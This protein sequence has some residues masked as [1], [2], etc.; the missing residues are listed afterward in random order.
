MTTSVLKPRSTSKEKKR[1]LNAFEDSRVHRR[2]V[3]FQLTDSMIAKIQS[4][5]PT[6]DTADT[7][8][9]NKLV[10]DKDKLFAQ[11]TINFSGFSKLKNQPSSNQGCDLLAE[12][13]KNN[14]FTSRLS[15]NP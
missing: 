12:A 13:K 5:P 6:G 8:T 1:D 9:D 11:T 15:H 4:R 3:S 14:F 7:Q 10:P 2:Q